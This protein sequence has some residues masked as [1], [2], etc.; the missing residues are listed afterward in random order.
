M[1]PGPLDGLEAPETEDDG[2]FV[3][4]QNRYAGDYQ[5]Q[6][7]KVDGQEKQR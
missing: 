1:S 3:F 2:A 5:Y 6:D 7:D 4:A